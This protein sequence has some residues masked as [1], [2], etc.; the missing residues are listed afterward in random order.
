MLP[1]A[2]LAGGLASRLLPITKTIP[3]ALIKVSGQPFI[4]YQLAYL[5]KQGIKKIILCIGHLGEMI[6]S[7]VGDGSRF[8]LKILYSSDENRL[9][10]T[11]GAIKKA[12]SILD[13]EFFVLYGDTF[14]PIK[15]DV[16]EKAFLS[17]NKLCLMTILRNDNKWDRSNV[18]FRNNRFIEYN[19]QN[20][21]TEMRYIDYGLSVV[22]A[23]IFDSYSNEAFFDLSSVY[24]SLSTKKQLEGFEVYE[25]FYEIGTPNSLAETEKYLLNSNKY[26]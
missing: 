20:P 7:Y 18:I 16:V 3:K 24:E 10:G 2:I 12:L 14:L 23:S 13:D 22:S 15:F 25:R 6:K 19:K 5:R 21:S 11:G 1:V 8:D 17:S 9:L 26:R 4:F